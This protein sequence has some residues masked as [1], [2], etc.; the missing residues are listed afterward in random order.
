MKPA[1]LD[2]QRKGFSIKEIAAERKIFKQCNDRR[3]FECSSHEP[4]SLFGLLR[5]QLVFVIEGVRSRGNYSRQ[6]S[7]GSI[8]CSSEAEIL[9]PGFSTIRTV[10]A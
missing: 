1:L 4:L 2:L 8:G 6:P 7:G 10:L 5:P 3:G 9:E